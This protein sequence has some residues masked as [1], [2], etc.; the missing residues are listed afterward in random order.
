MRSRGVCHEN[1]IGIHFFVP[2]IV[3]SS[4]QSSGTH[5]QINGNDSSSTPVAGRSWSRL[6][7]LFFDISIPS[8]L[9]F[10]INFSRI[11]IH[12]QDGKWIFPSLSD[13]D[14]HSFLRNWVS[15][16]TEFI[17]P[18]TACTRVLVSVGKSAGFWANQHLQDGQAER[19]IFFTYFVKDNISCKI[20]LNLWDRRYLHGK[21]IFFIFLINE[22]SLIIFLE[23]ILSGIQI[24]S[25][26]SITRIFD[27]LVRS[28]FIP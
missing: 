19:F 3:V 12:T 25:S 21:I 18:K 1:R 6:N 9:I 13:R 11:L 15:S 22:E 28:H 10:V 8:W 5:D 2:S 17:L 16:M 27:E 7:K 4:S 20:I 26:V 23:R 24:L 14:I